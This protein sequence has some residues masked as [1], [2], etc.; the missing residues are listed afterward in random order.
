MIQWI[1]TFVSGIYVGQE[2]NG[3][4]KI[5]TIFENIMILSRKKVESKE[6]KQDTQDWYTYLLEKMYKMKK[7]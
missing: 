4:P 7:E 5:K 2:F 3:I 6:P 1:I